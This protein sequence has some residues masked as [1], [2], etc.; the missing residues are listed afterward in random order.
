MG[1][2]GM[3][4]YDAWQDRKKEAEE[5]MAASRAAAEAARQAMAQGDTITAREQWKAAVALA[6]DAKSAYKSLNTEVKQ[7]DTTLISKADALKQAMSGV[8]EAGELGLD[9]LKEQ[10]KSVGQAMQDM[11]KNVGLDKLTAGMDEAEKKWLESW[12]K[13]GDAASEAGAQVEQVYNVWKNASG[14]WTN[15]ADAFSAGW[16]RTADKGRVEFDGMWADF[17]KTGKKAADDVS[18]ALD[19]ATK[20]RTVKIYTQTIE[21]R[22]LGGLIG[23]AR[24]ARGGKLAGF[25]GGDRISALLEAG[26]F[27]MRKEAVARFGTGFFDALNHLRLPD[28]SA[29]LPVAPVSALAAGGAGSRMTLELRLPGGDSVH[30][31]VSGDGAGIA[32]S[33]IWGPDDEPGIHPARPGAPLPACHPARALRSAQG[34]LGGQTHPRRG[35]QIQAR[36][37][38]PGSGADA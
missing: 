23:A 6:D 13:M 31:S 4:D 8:K 20:A 3:S 24:L 19:R 16:S 35:T 27:V 32:G 21:K 37:S 28:W 33:H 17:E 26:E 12:R 18:Q 9:A 29:L 38:H 25:G 34:H 2:G 14:Y 22:A 15:T 7:G 11:E 10:Q 36:D 30:A 1:R 5:Y